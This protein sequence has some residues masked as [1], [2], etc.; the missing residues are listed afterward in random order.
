MAEASDVTDRYRRSSECAG[1]NV[2]ERRAI[3]EKDDAQAD[4]LV[5]MGKAAMDGEESKASTCCF[6]DYLTAC[7][8]EYFWDWKEGFPAMIA[9]VEQS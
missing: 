8:S 5:L 6:S 3:L 1:R 9:P 4:P 7:F 2:G